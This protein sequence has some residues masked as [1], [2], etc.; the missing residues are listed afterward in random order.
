MT[1]NVIN[2]IIEEQSEYIKRTNTGMQ[3]EY[4]VKE[5]RKLLL[6][7]LVS[8]F[9]SVFPRNKFTKFKNKDQGFEMI[10]I[11]ILVAANFINL[12]STT[13]IDYLAHTYP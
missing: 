8:H 7:K 2:M 4:T 12:I 10:P 9:W 1:E 3:K 5:F 6:K 13:T 11:A